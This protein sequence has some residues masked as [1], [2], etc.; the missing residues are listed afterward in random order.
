MIVREVKYYSN[1]ASPFSC[2]EFSLQPRQKLGLELVNWHDDLELLTFLEGSATALCGN[3]RIQVSAGET[4]VINPNIIHT[5]DANENGT[6]YICLI[7]SNAFCEANHIPRATFFQ[8]FLRDEEIFS[9]MKKLHAEHPIIA[10]KSNAQLTG[11][12]TKPERIIMRNALVMQ[13][14]ARLFCTYRLPEGTKI[15]DSHCPKSI[16]NALE[17]AHANSTEDISLDRIAE[18]AGL[19]RYHFSRE[20][21]RVTQQS[22]VTY[23]NTLRCEKA[24]RFLAETEIPI[25]DICLQCGFSNGEYFSRVFTNAIGITPSEYRKRYSTTYS[26]NK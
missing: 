17:Y 6:R 21:R 11:N 23:L 14:L 25:K 13:I 7:I 1:A 2:K 5:V 16:R 9:L 10:R 15:T 18:V 8:E 4:L 12:D 3:H 24:M 26:N 19:S 20:F 22:F